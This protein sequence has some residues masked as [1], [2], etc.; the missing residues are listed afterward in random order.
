MATFETVDAYVESLPPGIREQLAAV[1]AVIRDAAPGT[2]EAISYGIPARMLDGRYVV[3]FAGW[4]RHISIYPIPGGDAALDAAMGPYLSGKGTLRFPMGKPIP[5][6][7]IAR[8]TARLLGQ[9]MD[10]SR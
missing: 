9:R 4:K 1:R 8:V 5:L 2:S 6:D 3:Y 10:G 7:L